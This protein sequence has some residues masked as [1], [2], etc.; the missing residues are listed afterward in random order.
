MTFKKKQHKME[1]YN[2]NEESLQ[3]IQNRFFNSMAVNLLISE[4]NFPYS[5][6]SLVLETF[7]SKCKCLLI[8][9]QIIEMP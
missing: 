1:G 9:V 5:A 8:G 7:D 2:N 4:N 3:S 6:Q